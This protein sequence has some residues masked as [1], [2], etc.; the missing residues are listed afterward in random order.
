MIAEIPSE[1][2]ILELIGV[3]FENCNSLDYDG[4]GIYLTVSSEA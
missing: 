1:N 4:G 2:S 3:I